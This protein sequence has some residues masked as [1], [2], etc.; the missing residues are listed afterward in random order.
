MKKYHWPLSRAADLRIN[1]PLHV[2]LIAFVMNAG[3]SL[4]PA[5]KFTGEPEIQS[6]P[7][8]PEESLKRLRVEAGLRIELVA[9]EPLIS[10]PVDVAWDEMGRMYVVENIG[11]NAAVGARPNSRIR[12]LEDT[13][14]DGRMD[15]ATTYSEDLDYAQGI[16]ATRG[17]LVVTTNT[18]ILFLRDTDGDGRA[19]VHEVLFKCAP[20]IHVDRQMSAPRR[21]ID[22]WIYINLGLFKQE[23][24]RPKTP[25]QRMALTNN[26][27]YHPVTGVY[28]P[29]SGAGQ[30]G[31][32][33][34][35]W[36]HEFFSMNRNPALF[37]V[38]P[39]HYLRRN[40]PALLTRSDED[41]VPAGGDGK[42]FPLQTF[43][44]TASAHAGTF[45]AACG[46]GVY[47]G[48]LLG[49]EY[50][51]NVFVC[52]PTGELVSRWILEPSGPSFRGHRAQ[53][54][55]EFLA[56]N[57]EW[58]RP[59]NVTTGPDGALYIVDMYRRFI[60]GS[61]FF[62][63]A[64]I[65]ANDMAAG[66]DRGHIYRVV[67]V[68]GATV[69]RRIPLPTEPAKRVALLEHPNGWHRDTAQR[70][71]VEA[72][73]AA[74]LPAVENVFRHSALAQGRLHALWTIEGLNGLT[75]EHVALALADAEPGVVE[76][77]LWL[78]PRFLKS[79]DAIRRRV[80]ELTSN[81]A[82]RV[83]FA[84]LLGAGGV[85]GHEAEQA[86]VRAG[87]READDVW[88]RT[89]IL[90]SRLTQSSRILTA[91]L[92]D[93][94]F[95]AQ[96][97][98]SQIELV[99]GLAV[100]LAAQGIAAELK[101]VL[102]ALAGENVGPHGN[103]WRMAL[104]GGIAEGLRRQTTAAL[105]R[106]ISALLAKPPAEL[107]DS[108]AGLR[109]AVAS[110]TRVLQDRSRP[111]NERTAAVAMLEHLPAPETAPLVGALLHQSEPVEIQKATL[112]VLAHLDRRALTPMLY[113]YLP[114]M[115][116]GARSGAMQYLQKSPI[117][118]L[119]RIKAGEINPALVDATGRWMMLNSGN[120]EI[121]KLGQEVFGKTEG[122][123]KALVRRYA[124]AVAA[125][126]AS[127]VR[128]KEI[129]AQSCAICHRFRGQGNDLGP[130]IT[131]VRIKTPEML[132]SDILDPNN[133]VD[134]RFEAYSLHLT[135]G[136]T[137]AGIIA[138][139]TNDAIVVAGIGGS[140]KIPRISL[141]TSAPL[142]ASLMPLGLEASLTEQRMAD[143]LAYIRSDADAK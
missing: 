127:A 90:S 3:A 12:V 47:R 136:R 78:S 70:L 143:L 63:D 59:V 134:P 50:L 17:G 52:E 23:V 61:R 36:G 84:A 75:A 100:V 5:A 37:A 64:Y 62:P 69:P 40:P 31:K 109:N 96:G 110:A 44:T 24:Y 119:K 49:R 74:V 72:G 11:Y 104:V 117:E 133:A 107:A 33:F 1:R 113:K 16:L 4:L 132:L 18:G 116:S 25:D 19:D 73:D 58:F 76:N 9:A 91:L 46:T 125:L 95:V 67:P 27:R 118:L 101:P 48:D 122:D 15:R 21:G 13:D 65:A 45:T 56:S 66:S 103:W 51:N 14:G 120:D 20:S 102:A 124:P 85:A 60:D 80:L 43:R 121:R 131:D 123:R 38:L 35:D 34:D 30:F 98:R 79:D 114:E 99:S 89:A 139:E 41:V 112:D 111:I 106:S 108:L 135:D 129:F 68:T 42:V 93:R 130:D 97:S 32:A 39:Y 126:P 141:K 6:R 86:L 115:G 82:G 55:R 81:P 105:P 22:N 137:V 140:E 29:S 88:M 7:L 77:A 53:P 54:G 128:G 142:G 10:D 2:L 8:A 92:Q 83:R 71:L 57:D 87:A 26:F 28:E 138:S 94:T